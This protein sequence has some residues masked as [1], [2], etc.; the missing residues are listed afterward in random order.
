V[1]EIPQVLR[2]DLYAVA[3]LAGASIVVIGDVFGFPHGASAV[4]GGILCFGLRFVAIRYGWHLPVAHLSAQGRARIEI[5][6][7]TRNLA[8]IA[9]DGIM[10]AI[11]ADD[12]AGS[13]AKA[14]ASARRST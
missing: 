14:A 2:S 4:A 7:T 13:P 9:V 10:R 3:A 12:R 11:D 8:E 6:R 1:T 5:L